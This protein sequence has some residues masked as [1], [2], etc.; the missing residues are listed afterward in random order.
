MKD[1]PLASL[2]ILFY[3]QEGFVE[4]TIKGALSQTYDNLEIILSDDCSPDKTFEKIKEF[5]KDYKGPHKI[6][7]NRNEINMGLVPHVNKVIFE[8]SKGN[9]LFLNGGDDIS[10]PNRVSDGVSLFEKNPK[11]TGVTFSRLIINKDGQEIS[12]SIVENQHICNINDKYY[13][14]RP[15][16]MAGAGA[17]SFRRSVIDYF[18]LLN[19]DCQTDDSVWRFRSL[20]L[21]GILCSP[22]FGLK[23]R[24]HDNNISKF[25][26]NFNTD[27]IANQYERD[28]IKAKGIISSKLYKKL[29]KK[30]KFYRISRHVQE[31]HERQTNI[32]LKF[33]VKLLIKFLVVLQILFV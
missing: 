32:V 13:L 4:D 30:I 17:F 27:L 16:F 14:H 5:V 19:S 8:L 7:I 2:C 28:L 18:G 26:S 6:I 9:Y 3:R 1:K 25:I 10:L 11:V 33:F 23:Y 31:L 22:L 12:K 20:L 21:G 24:V 29:E 15:T